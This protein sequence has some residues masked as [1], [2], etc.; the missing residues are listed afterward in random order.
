MDISEKIQKHHPEANILVLNLTD[1]VDKN[2]ATR[3]LAT[4]ILSLGNMI[5]IEERKGPAQYAIISD[6][7]LLEC[8]TDEFGTIGGIQIKENTE[9]KNCVIIGRIDDNAKTEVTLNLVL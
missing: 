7:K 9:L 4:R 5:A 2:A 8:I 6:I 3:R 1:A